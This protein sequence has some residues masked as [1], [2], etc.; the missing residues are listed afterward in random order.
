MQQNDEYVIKVGDEKIIASSPVA[1]ISKALDIEVT[2]LSLDECEITLNDND[3]IIK[4]VQKDTHSKLRGDLLSYVDG[5][6]SS[7]EEFN[8]EFKLSTIAS[9]QVEDKIDMEPHAARQK[10]LREINKVAA[11]LNEAK[12]TL[13][14]LNNR[15]TSREDLNARF[16]SELAI[17]WR[18]FG[19][20]V[21]LSRRN[22]GHQLTFIKNVFVISQKTISL[23][24]RPFATA[25]QMT[26]ST[27]RVINKRVKG[28]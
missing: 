27:L 4:S 6:L 8:T 22:E 5:E 12:A 9:A 20:N 25:R 18:L 28:S 21:E 3:E 10:R 1:V 24:L 26:V 7:Q 15:N 14:F 2:E 19:S 23:S 17:S 13:D 16:K 11:G